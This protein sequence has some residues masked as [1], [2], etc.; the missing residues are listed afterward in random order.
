MTTFDQQFDRAMTA[1]GKEPKRQVDDV[2]QV[3]RSWESP[4][5]I[6]QV[7]QIQ[8]AGSSSPR[9]VIQTEGVRSLELLPPG[10]LERQIK[11]DT[12]SKRVALPKKS[13]LDDLGFTSQYT[14]MLAGKKYA[15]LT[16]GRSHGGH[17]WIL[18]ELI[19]HKVATGYRVIVA[20][21][22]QRR[23]TSQ[24]GAFLDERQITKTG[25]DFAEYLT[26]RTAP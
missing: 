19:K 6:R 1:A 7:I 25:M 16:Q 9:L 5:G 22:G 13:L 24:D 18:G 15:A 14:P 11:I 2:S 23:L 3:G 8:D 26:L 10:D 21:S 12:Q 17:P 20:S 4:L